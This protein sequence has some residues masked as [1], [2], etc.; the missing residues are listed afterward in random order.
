MLVHCQLTNLYSTQ[1][2]L[3]SEADYEFDTKLDLEQLWRQYLGKS[4]VP[5][6][7][8]HLN[9]GNL[10]VFRNK[11]KDLVRKRRGIL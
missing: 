2:D 8:E 9:Q 5:E 4:L 7:M 6:L 3:S 10:E 1:G 11:L